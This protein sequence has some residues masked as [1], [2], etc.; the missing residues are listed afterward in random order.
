MEFNVLDSIREEHELLLDEMRLVTR[1][2]GDVRREL[3]DH[4][5]ESMVK[6]LYAVEKV[7]LTRLEQEISSDSSSGV[8]NKSAREHHEL[9]EYLQRLT[10]MH[11]DD[12]SWVKMFRAFEETVIQYFEEEE[13]ELFDE[14]KEDYSKDELIEIGTD[15]NN[16]R[17]QA[18]PGPG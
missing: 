17:A 9:K 2:E 6:H 14:L 5:K 3:F 16:E 7:I 13:E 11:T 8:S 15:Y 4:I 1:A 12:E 10:L 18:K